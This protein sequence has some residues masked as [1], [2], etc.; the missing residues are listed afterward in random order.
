[1]ERHGMRHTQIY[2]VWAG[3]KDRTNPQHKNHKNNY[4]KLNISM[5]E[6]WRNSF[7]SFYNWAISNG[8]KEE[9]LPN[10]KNKY[11]IDRIDCYGDYCPENCRWITADEQMNNTTKNKFIEYNGQVKTL[12]EWCKEL[13]LNYGL[14]NQRLHSGFDVERAFT[15]SNDRK[16]YYIYKGERLN[17]KDI[18][19]RTGLTI[20]NVWNRINR[21][22]GIDRIMEQPARGGKRN[23]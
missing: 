22:W 12:S 17:I 8:Y 19:E 4:R 13:G 23:V 11:T 9:K 21:G 7:L 18:S 2:G 16:N 5:C 1:M 20:T 3:T 6:E 15:E 14:V 10:G